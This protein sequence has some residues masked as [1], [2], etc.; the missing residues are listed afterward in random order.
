M[1]TVK[2]SGLEALSLRILGIASWDRNIVLLIPE[3]LDLDKGFRTGPSPGHR[4]QGSGWGNS[5][6]PLL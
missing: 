4:V 6:Q 3:A 2:R 1:R 5:D